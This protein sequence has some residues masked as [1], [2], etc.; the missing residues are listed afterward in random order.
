MEQARQTKENLNG[1]VENIV[2]DVTSKFTS[3]R[4]SKLP[5]MLVYI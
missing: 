1:V 2:L 5:E 3:Q 4:E